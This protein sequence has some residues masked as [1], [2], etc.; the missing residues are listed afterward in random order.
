MTYVSMLYANVGM[1][2]IL[3]YPVYNSRYKVNIYAILNNVYLL[4]DESAD[5]RYTNTIKK[6]RRTDV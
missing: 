6:R 4:R 5:G 3:R 1:L 2:F